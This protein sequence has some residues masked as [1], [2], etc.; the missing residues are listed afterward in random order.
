MATVGSWA[1]VT[2]AAVGFGGDEQVEVRSALGGVPTRLAALAAIVVLL[3]L[4]LLIA[5]AVSVSS[6]GPVL[7]RQQ[8]VGRNGRLF[9]IL[10]FRTMCADAEARLD[11]LLPL[12]EHDGVLFKLRCDPRITAV[13]HVLRRM[14]L[15]ELPQLWNIVRG[16]MAFVGPRPALP[17][18]VAR[19]DPGT[20]ARL[21]VKPGLTGLW[22]VSGR[23]LLSWEDSVRLDLHYVF[24]R[25][26]WLNASIVLR[27]LSAVL[28]GRGA[29]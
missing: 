2:E 26:L 23:S 8:R 9:T 12:N 13:G 1:P 18:E 6:P 21:L 22:Q 14:S 29:F 4:L 15:D 16:E 20:R 27:T 25:S 10:K 28:T 17:D 11:D 24:H 7:F 3:P 19:Y 5:V